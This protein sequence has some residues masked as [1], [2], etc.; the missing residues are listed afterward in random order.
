[1]GKAHRGRQS[2][3]VGESSPSCHV[4]QRT[5]RKIPSRWGQLKSLAGT[6]NVFRAVRDLGS[7]GPDSVLASPRNKARVGSTA[8]V[9]RGPH[10]GP[11]R[12]SP[13]L[14]LDG[15]CS[16]HFDGGCPSA[17]HAKVPSAQRAFCAT[18]QVWPASGI[19]RRDI[20]VLPRLQAVLQR[21]GRRQLCS[22]HLSAASPS[23]EFGSRESSTP[24]AV[25]LPVVD[26]VRCML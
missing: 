6:R 26:F 10:L 17:A 1:M 25:R 5:F 20:T 18:V 19:G 13:S 12:V 9:E 4:S 22:R 11:A 16:M 15:G 23:V 3:E 7:L 14:F 2:V 21:M 24:R 8:S